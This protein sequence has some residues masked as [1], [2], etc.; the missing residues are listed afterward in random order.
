MYQEGLSVP[1]VTN[2]QNTPRNITEERMRN[3]IA[4]E[5]RKLDT[6]KSAKRSDIL[7]H[8]VSGF[9]YGTRTLPSGYLHGYH[10][11]PH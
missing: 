3:Y 9:F 2:Y 6:K 4:A 10:G 5:Y 11:S 7:G 8:P 1:Q